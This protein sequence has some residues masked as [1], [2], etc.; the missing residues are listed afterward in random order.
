M[1]NYYKNIEGDHISAI[2]TGIGDVE[3]TQEEYDNI[4]SVIRA[5]PTAEP[6]FGYKLRTDLTWET[7]E[8]P[9]IDPE[10]MEISGEQF[11]DMVEE[12]L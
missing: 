3:I 6:G 10:D 4:L 8:V 7:C 1:S 11:K 12:V 2:G 9:I 5:K